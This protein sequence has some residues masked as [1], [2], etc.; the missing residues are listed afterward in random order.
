MPY[1]LYKGITKNSLFENSQS[2]DIQMATW[3]SLKACVAIK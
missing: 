1:P 3:K 2:I